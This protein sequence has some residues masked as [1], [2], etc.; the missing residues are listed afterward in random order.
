MSERRMK[1]G[2]IGLDTGHVVSTAS[3]FHSAGQEWHVPG[4]QVTVACADTNPDFFNYHRTA[5]YTKTLQENYGV[6]IVD[7]LEEVARECDVIFLSSIDARAHHRQFLEIA[8]FRK[9]V[10]VEK[11]LALLYEDAVHMVEIAEANAVPLFC[12]SSLRY[13]EA[14]VRGIQDETGGRILGADVSGPLPIEPQLPGMFWYGVHVTEL[15][16]A[17]LGT[18][19]KRVNATMNELHEV[20]V[21]EWEDGRIGSVR[22][23][24]YGNSLY[25]AVLFREQR[26]QWIDVRSHP[27]P[28]FSNFLEKVIDMVRS[29]KS[30]VSP[31]E[32]LSV[33]RFME[34]SNES[35]LSGKAVRL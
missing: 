5:A 13:A 3:L 28:D 4:A 32:M 29:G 20:I 15:L 25:S 27:R 17:S 23:N 7:T 22:G 1:I 8:E 2:L 11:P 21:G 19:C 31:E 18:G 35:R 24:R 16:F 9:P 30:P 12:C 34:A 6:Q 10:V 33:I 26:A 14:F